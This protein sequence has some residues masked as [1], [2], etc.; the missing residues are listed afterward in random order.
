[1]INS[2]NTLKKKEELGNILV[3]NTDIPKNYKTWP[4]VFH[5]GKFI[6]GYSELIELLENKSY[7]YYIIEMAFKGGARPRKEKK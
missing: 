2:K 6:G 4:R 5:K 1:M 3:Q 7:F